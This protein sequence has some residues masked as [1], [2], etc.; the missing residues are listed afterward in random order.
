MTPESAINAQ[1]PPL[2]NVPPAV[3]PLPFVAGDWLGEYPPPRSLPLD[4][5]ALRVFER[6][7]AI[8]ATLQLTGPPITFGTLIV[9]LFQGEDETSRWFTNL[10]DQHGP[11][12]DL[13]YSYKQWD[14]VALETI[15]P[16]EGKPE[17]VRLSDDKQIMTV[18]AR[19]VLG[20]AEGWALRVGGTDIGVR[21]LVA[22][23]VL[24][25]PPEHRSEMQ[26]WSYQ[27]SKWR[28][29][30]FAWVAERYT[31]ER[32]TDASQRPA[33][34]AATLTFERP[35]VKGEELAFPGDEQ[36]LSV[37]ELAAQYHA[38]RDERWLRLQTVFH[39]LVQEAR[40]ESAVGAAITP[41]LD[42]VNAPE[43]PYQALFQEFSSS[44]TDKPAVPFGKLDVSP[45]VL[46]ALETARGL[47]VA[48]RSDGGAEPLVSVVHLAGALFSRRVDS[49][50]ALT[51]MGVD[52][53]ALR[54][55]LI[56]T[57]EARGE[58]REVWSEA[59]GYEEDVQAGRPLELNSD[60][61]ESAVR[62]DAGWLSDPLGIRRDV[63]TFAALLA[64]KSLEPPLSIGLFGPWGSGKTTFLKRLQR[65]VEHLAEEAG[66][67][68]TAGQPTP[69]VANVVHVDF[70][71]WHFA[72]GALT[73]SL[74][75]KIL[76]ELNKHMKD[77]K[78]K[79]GTSWQQQTIQKLETTSR[80]MEAAEAVANAA[81][82]AVTKAE[83]TLTESRTRAAQAATSFGE[84][85]QR[86]WSAAKTQLQQSDVVEKSGV[87]KALGDTISST[88]EL[89]VQLETL[90]NRPAR[91]LG[92]LG[93]MRTI[94]FAF[95][96]LVLPPLVAWFVK[97]V[98]QTNDAA[99]VLASAT[100]ALSMVGLW[101]RA[102]TGAVARVDK[103]VADVAAEYDKHLASHPDIKKAQHD[104]DTAQAS[105]ATAAAGLE[106][107]REELARA[108]T[109]AAN[110]TLPAQMLQLVSSRLDADTYNK[111]LTTLSLAR[112][113]LEALT[114]LLRDQRTAPATSATA[115]AGDNVP[116]LRTRVVDRVILYIDDLDRCKPEDVVRV[117]QL[118]HMLLAFEL[119]VVV[120][121]V[122]ARWV[123]ESLK[124][125]YDWLADDKTAEK[126]GD[127]A[128]RPRPDMGHLTPQDYLEK[129]F[130]IAFWLEPM[131]VS[132]AADYLGSLVRTSVRESGP[133]VGTPTG[134]EPP[135][136]HPP[137][138]AIAAIELDYMRYLAAYVGSS[139]R[140]VKRFVNAYRLIKAGLSDKQIEHFIT[141][142]KAD[143]GSIRSGPYQLVIGLLVIGTGAPASSAQILTELAECHPGQSM[144]S[145]VDTLR[146]RNHP[147]WTMAAQVIEA[148]MQSQKAKNVAELRGWA[149]KVRRFLLNGGQPLNSAVVR[150]AVAP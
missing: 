107:A 70:N 115:P 57:A 141:E 142:R 145:V 59:L 42:A 129:I 33:P 37:L 149:R 131:T 16:P 116:A 64:S 135:G 72:E 89:R 54:Y 45:R 140:R 26:R 32:W 130:Q 21:H 24:N 62:L 124:Q 128:N 3:R 137:K 69:Y 114:I 71:A 83:T 147:D 2:S 5:E 48:T 23:Y 82:E 30:F 13:V 139:P 58:S 105:A 98:L 143:D 148:L 77:E 73:S 75:D 127:G 55:A 146:S 25:P 117:L 15:K 27:E 111:E 104:L 8:G 38:N 53:Q 138:V 66:K 7:H 102:A 87:L 94:G 85:V 96:V 44:H 126:M 20:S 134:N 93:W 95:I 39:A 81:Q 125:S 49:E 106:S 52:V 51:P 34:A 122:D 6:A 63:K 11:K 74:V 110:A 9:A 61:P 17:A 65:V 22:S 43:S 47:A 80:K 86:V 56:K 90:R 123:A 112:A 108:R 150:P 136:S 103:A 67:A 101:A 40:K 144:E 46:N 12:P 35:E 99:Q 120:V 76:R 91:L 41:V 100:A 4:Q 119:F 88:E 28:T 84:A 92:D 14:R 133:V 50:E 118:V 60:E 109:E 19:N 29:E 18:S 31:A 113:D 36:T 132:Q 79:V 78:E 68:N 1:T 10:A 121:A 97:T